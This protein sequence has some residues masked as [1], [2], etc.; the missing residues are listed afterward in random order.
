[1]SIATTLPSDVMRSQMRR[2]AHRLSGHGASISTV[3]SESA[4]VS[5]NLTRTPSKTRKYVDICDAVPVLIRG[6]SLIAL[7]TGLSGRLTQGLRAAA[8]HRYRTVAIRIRADCG[9]GRL[10]SES[11]RPERVA[12][13]RPVLAA[14]AP[15]LQD[16]GTIP[17]RQTCL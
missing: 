3:V 2:K 1:M 13:R 6:Y 14:L 12:R 11:V 4:L 5:A 9:T 7:Q 10:R 17:F 16:R 15:A 8:G